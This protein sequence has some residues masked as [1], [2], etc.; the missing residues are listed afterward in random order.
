MGRFLH[1][2][3]GTVAK[4]MLQIV[5]VYKNKIWYKVNILAAAK[6]KAEDGEVIVC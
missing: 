4:E 3:A 6:E 1:D 5:P 2:A